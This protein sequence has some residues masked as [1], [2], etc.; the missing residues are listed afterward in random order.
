MNLNQ[1]VQ[2]MQPACLDAENCEGDIPV[3]DCNSTF[4][5]IRESNTTSIEQNASC[6]FISAPKDQLVATTDEFLFK[7]LGIEDNKS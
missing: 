2:R 6:V 4:I 7:I 3:K 5:I 1:V